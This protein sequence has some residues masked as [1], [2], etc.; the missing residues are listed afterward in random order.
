MSAGILY[1]VATPIG[2]LSDLSERAIDTLKE[3]DLIACED[4]RHSKKL[5]FHF[6]IE[7]Q[8]TALHDHN[9][10]DRVDSLLA[11]LSTG[12]SLALISDAGTPLISDPGYRLVKTAQ[13]QGIK[14]S[15]IPGPCAAMAALSVAG[16]AS[17]HFYF[18]GFL[19]AKQSGRLKR[20][21]ELQLRTETLIF[22]EA[23]HRVL[24]TL[25]DLCEV[26]G[27]ERQATLAREL[28]K[29]YETIHS[30]NLADL[31]SFVEEDE[32]QRRGEIVLLVAG[33]ETN[34]E[35][36]M[37]EA[38]RVYRILEKDLPMKQAVALAA[39]ITAVKKNSLYKA[40]LEE[41]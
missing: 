37:Q 8:L 38:L 2:N 19:P 12:K 40:V 4:T 21:Q 20:L 10:Q 23:P 26:L 28:T 33:C 35:A 7:T 9:E 34:V 30:D 6:G 31:A 1:I 27:G 14:I 17:D 36:A 39:K 22:Y 16:L 11:E 24:E 18:E 41:S 29:L 5:L 32:N 3:V 25:Q 15:P 13:Q